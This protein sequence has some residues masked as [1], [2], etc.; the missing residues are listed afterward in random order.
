MN[1]RPSHKT[2]VTYTTNVRFRGRLRTPWPRRA[3]RRGRRHPMVASRQLPTPMTTNAT[4][5]N[6]ECLDERYRPG[7]RRAFDDGDGAGF[8]YSAAGAGMV[9]F[10]LNHRQLRERGIYEQALLA[11][12]TDAK[13]NNRHWPLGLLKDWLH[14]CDRAKLIAAGDPLSA[15]LDRSFFIAESPA[16]PDTAAFAEFT[17]PEN[18]SRRY[19]LPRAFVC[20]RPPFTESWHRWR[21][22][23]LTPNTRMSTW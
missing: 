23:G 3:R 22:C 1:E 4:T 5:P 16:N 12:F 18:S 8:I 2:K 17:G 6:L 7:A 21:A 15:A 19:G 13:S 14:A 10:S 20:P 11:A 9:L